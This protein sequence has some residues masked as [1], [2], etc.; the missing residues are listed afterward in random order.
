MLELALRVAL[1]LQVVNLP[2]VALVALLV[3]AFEA[4]ALFRGELPDD[5]I[6]YDSSL[7]ASVDQARVEPREPLRIK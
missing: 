5:L 4:L 3:Q 1:Y 7:K 6:I 2:H